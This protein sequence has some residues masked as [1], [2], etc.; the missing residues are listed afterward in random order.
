MLTFKNFMGITSEITK[1]LFQQKYKKPDCIL[2]RKLS[3]LE[4]ITNNYDFQNP[5]KHGSVIKNK[6]VAYHHI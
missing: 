4:A 6:H 1:L 3:I 2:K 5:L